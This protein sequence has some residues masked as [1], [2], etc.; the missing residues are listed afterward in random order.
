VTNLNNPNPIYP[1]VTNQPFPISQLPR[2]D[3][4]MNKN[5]GNKLKKNILSCV[6]VVVFCCMILLV[7][8]IWLWFVGDQLL[9]IGI[10]I[11]MSLI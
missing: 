3:A 7:G 8:G 5:K 6:L 11:V 2:N 10:Q 1:V 4:A 9:G